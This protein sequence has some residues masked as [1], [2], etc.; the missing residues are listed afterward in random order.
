MGK[1]QNGQMSVLLK[2]NNKI[3]IEWTL[4]AYAGYTSQKYT[5]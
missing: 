1:L 5:L 4:K 3:E 2:K